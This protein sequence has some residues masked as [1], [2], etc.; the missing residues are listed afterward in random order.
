MSATKE[1]TN[2]PAIAAIAENSDPNRAGEAIRRAVE[3]AGG[4]EWLE[5]GQKVVIKPALNSA[6]K[7]PFTSSPIACAELVRMCLERGAAKV[8]VADEMGFEHTMTKHWKTGKFAGF[9]KDKTIQA[10]KKT[11]IFDAV[12]Q[13]AE[14]L[15]ARD[16][17]HITTF[18]EH[19]WRRHE[20]ST[21]IGEDPKSGTTLHSQWARDQL[22]QVEKMCGTTVKR[23]Y[24]PRHFDLR[25]K[26]SVPG[27]FVPNLL[28]EVD[29]I[30]NLFRVSAHVWSHY[31]MAIKNWVGIM[32]PDDR[33]W[34]HQFNYLKNNRHI[35]YGLDEDAPIRSEPLYHELLADLHLPH[36]E[37]ERLCVAD[38]TQIVLTGGP[39]DTDRLFCNAN[40][41]LA[42]QDLIAADVVSL[43]ILRYGT[44]KATDGLLGKYGPQPGS[45]K[46]AI[47]EA[48]KDLR[49]PE[50][51]K[52]VFRGTDSK[53]CDPEFSNWDWV[54]VQRARELGLGI[55]GPNELQ[56]VFADED[57]PFAV[58]GEKRDWLTADSLRPP[59]YNLLDKDA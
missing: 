52:N 7:F 34:M 46:E 47:K 6:G 58:C 19:G 57:S 9:E 22:K 59:R 53:L 44:L 15:D 5:P 37:K 12:M 3:L 45:W 2:K 17:V 33:V 38:A 10:F 35:P 51:G 49:W 13:V 20:F 4:M 30:I 31:T 28:D 23:K 11:G 32:R 54:A 14:E 48:Y 24:I 1:I 40:L 25:L 18:R 55:G 36:I 39:D 29:H 21:W 16:R 43:A 27:L 56:L 41:M 26:K 8:Y 42:T 50:E